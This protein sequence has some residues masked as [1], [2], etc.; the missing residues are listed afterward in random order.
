MSKLT[1]AKHTGGVSDCLLQSVDVL[2]S[3]RFFDVLLSSTSSRF[4][5]ST[6]TRST[7]QVDTITQ[8]NGKQLEN[9][10]QCTTRAGSTCKKSANRD[11][12]CN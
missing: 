9:R 2:M 8:L 10:I 6:G 11:H 1:V 4:Y 7:P 5:A 3:H 12:P